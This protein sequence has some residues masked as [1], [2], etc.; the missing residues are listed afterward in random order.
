MYVHADI[1]YSTEVPFLVIFD[2][3]EDSN[4]INS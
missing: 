4:L 2:N 1:G 3:A